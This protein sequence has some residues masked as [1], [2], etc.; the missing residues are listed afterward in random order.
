MLSGNR[1]KLHLGRLQ[2][3]RAPEFTAGCTRDWR[4]QSDAAQPRARQRGTRHT[5]LRR[6]ARVAWESAESPRGGMMLG[7]GAPAGLRGT[8]SAVNGGSQ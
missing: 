6:V 1:T 2:V 7:T 4:S 3:Q 5:P 8:R